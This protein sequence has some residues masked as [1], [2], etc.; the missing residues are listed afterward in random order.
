[1][2]MK[3][4][5]NLRW[6]KRLATAGRNRDGFF[7]L[8]FT[9]VGQQIRLRVKPCRREIVIRTGSPDIKVALSCFQ[10]EFD[11][12]LNAVPKLRYPLIVD[13]GGYIGTAAIV[14]A[15]AYPDATVVSLEPST[16]NFALLKRNVAQYKNIVP[17]NKA[18]APQPGRLTLKDRGT[19]QWGFTLVPKPDDNAASAPTEEVECVT[20]D[21]LM[22]EFGADGIGILKL[23]IEGGEH[24]LLSRNTTWIDRTDAICIELHDRIVA[25][26]SDLYRAATAGRRNVKMEG[27]KYLSVALQAPLLQPA[28]EIGVRS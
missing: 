13:A 11:E 18:L 9:S 3:F 25:G 8:L 20:L 12:L 28:G 10:G 19:G 5:G 22:Q 24:A 17:V 23:D 4:R 7:W 6:A 16:Q 2:A 21:Q 1:M 26:C 14:F 15:E 27:E